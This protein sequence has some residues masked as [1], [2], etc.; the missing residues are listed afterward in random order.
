MFGTADVKVIKIAE[1]AALDGS[2]RPAPVITITFNVGNHGPF[3]ES[4]PKAG[5]DA[6]AANARLADFANRLGIIHGA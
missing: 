4:F 2:G 1:T 5:F 3:T 6:N